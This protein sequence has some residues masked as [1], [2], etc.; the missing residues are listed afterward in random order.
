MSD[1][2][3][4]RKYAAECRRMADLSCAPSIR[5]TYRRLESYWDARAS[6]LEKME[7]NPEREQPGRG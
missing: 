5:A 1:A 4:Y 2:K 7:N 6:E 3:T